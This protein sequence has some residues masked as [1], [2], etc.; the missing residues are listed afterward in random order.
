V[1]STPRKGFVYLVGA[2]PGRADL[3]TLR[4]VELI[5]IADCIVC[6]K[7]ASPTLL[8][9]ARK[10]AEIIHVPKRIGAGSFTQ[11][12]VNQILVE[13]ASAGNVVV[14]LKGGD[15]C[16][17]GRCTEE[18]TVLREAGIGFEIVPGVTA[19]IAAA[20]Y[21]GIMLT[22]R[23]YS[24]QV[25]FI[26]GHEAEGK[27]ESN[28]DWAVLARFPG[29]LVFYMGV[30]AL[31][32][33]VEKLIAAGRSPDT[34]AAIVAEA[35]LPTQRLVQ[36]PL[37]EIAKAC[38]RELIEPPALVIIG[39]AAAG[40]EGMNWFMTQPL[41]GRTIVAT[42][43]LEGNAEMAKAILARGGRAVEF[44]TLS[45]H[46]LTDRNEFLQTLA[47]ITGYDW[48]IF[49]SPNG[50]EVFF[51]AL[52]SLGKDA[53][54][55]GKISIAALGARTAES[56]A[57]YGIRSDF[58]PTV[59]TGAQLAI[60]LAAYTN[61]DKKK[62]LLLRSEIASDELPDRLEDSQAEVD[63]IPIYTASAVRTD[64]EPLM[65]QI[66]QGHIHWLT[67]ASP[68]SARAFFEQIPPAS[69]L[70]SSVKV[71][72]IGPVTGRQLAELGVRIDVEAAVHTIDGL[73]DA[74]ENLER[75]Q[76]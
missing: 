42:R 25:A 6:D 20:E 52:R 7:L 61:L 43:D 64:C 33:I 28:I 31:P 1:E 71:A 56:L 50:V 10:D 8:T 9:H 24:S 13:K 34:P 58:V 35:T 59:F 62:V 60:Q 5:R 44:A 51:E 72:S 18:L 2:G 68:S 74:I 49:T 66:Q 75:T 48:A 55:L 36:A 76:V 30:I 29:T 26:T 65:R 46:A 11:D 41:F 67:F 63:D 4:G 14:R 39:A 53:R 47:R 38:Q 16:I 27:E 3:I 69:V 22:D 19:A 12:Q 54:A 15:P 40:E 70:S 57:C 21:A 45:I 17:F 32:H 23:R 37:R 73:L